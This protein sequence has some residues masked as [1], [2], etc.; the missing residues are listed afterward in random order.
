MSSA[1]ARKVPLSNAWYVGTPSL[2][3]KLFSVADT[4]GNVAVDELDTGASRR[5]TTDAILQSPGQRAEF[6]TISP[7]NRFVA[8]TW[9]ALD[10]K[11]EL[12]IIDVDGRHP[13]VLVRSD[14]VD[15]PIPIEWSRDGKAV[16]TDITRPDH[17]KVLALVTAEDGTIRPIKELGVDGSQHASLSPDGDFLVYDA[18]QAV[19]AIPRDLFIIRSDGTE[20]RRLIEHP[21]NDASPIWTPDGRRV[22]FVSNRSG[23]TMDVW[24]VE[25]GGGIAQG[26]P[27][28]VHRNIGVMWLRGLTDAGSYFYY[29]SVGAVDVYQADIVNGAVLNS[30]TLPTSYAGSNISSVWSPDGK[31]LAFGSRRGLIGFDRGSI[32]LAVKDVETGQ[33]HDVVPALN[34]FILWSWSPD[35]RQILAQGT[36]A[37]GTTGNYLIDADTGRTTPDVLNGRPSEAGIAAGGTFMPDGRLLYFNRRKQA[38]L[39]RNIH[40]AAEDVVF[41]FRAEGVDLPDGQYKIGPDGQALALSVRAHTPEKPPTAVIVKMVGGGPWRELVRSQSNERVSFQDWTP[42]GQAV[43][44]LKWAHTRSSLWRV[45]IHGGDPVPLG[46]DMEGLRDV[47]VNPGG[48][49]I[50]FTAGWPMNELWVLENFLSR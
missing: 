46:L 42:D 8:Y 19:G 7:D 45:S 47:R 11:S 40:T 32:T 16:L 13:R 41:D 49:K 39:A 14:A 27:E 25:V 44:F 15:Y 43:L 3:G 21:A 33:Q 26:E 17:T 36:D 5:L 34:N 35:G 9:F 30:K 24:S 6:S 4:S 29:A 18:P 23:T 50:T 37:R 1:A 38:L 31:R 10:G 12:R 28:L 48:T 20:E 22:L 2:D